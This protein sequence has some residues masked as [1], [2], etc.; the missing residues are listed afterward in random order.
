MHAYS[1]L[2]ETSFSYAD[3]ILVSCRVD[4]YFQAL[5]EMC[6]CQ[7]NIICWLENK[8]S[9]FSLLWQRTSLV[10]SVHHH[11]ITSSHQCT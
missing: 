6:R 5:A 11:H 2:A 3:V 4:Y 7:Y 9:G 1:S 10:C 8:S